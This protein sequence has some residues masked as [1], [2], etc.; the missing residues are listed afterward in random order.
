MCACKKNLKGIARLLLAYGAGV[1]VQDKEGA[2]ALIFG[3]IN[4]NPEI[5]GMLLSQG[6][7]VNISVNDGSTPLMAAVEMNCDKSLVRMLLEH[8]SVVFARND[9][10]KTAY[11]LV[12]ERGNVEIIDLLKDAMQRNGNQLFRS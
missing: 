4:R 3:V 11:D 9:W 5:V 10:G 6:A 8:R 12:V 2:T 7:D 1:N